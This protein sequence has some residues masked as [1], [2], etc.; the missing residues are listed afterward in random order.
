MKDDGQKSRIGAPGSAMAINQSFAL[1]SGIAVASLSRGI[2]SKS[3]SVSCL[4]DRRELGDRKAGSVARGGALSLRR[5][6]ARQSD[7]V[8]LC[9]RSAQRPNLPDSGGSRGYRGDNG[10]QWAA[11]AAMRKPPRPTPRRALAA[12]SHRAHV[13]WARYR[14]RPATLA[15]PVSLAASADARPRRPSSK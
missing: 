15:Q 14:Q 4:G 7:G 5:I 6:A 2:S 10:T 3:K 11:L 1:Q 8:G 9:V 13:A 12:V